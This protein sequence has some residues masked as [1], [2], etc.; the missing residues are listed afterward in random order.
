[1]IYPLLFFQ[2]ELD[3]R[4]TT[5][6]GMADISSLRRRTNQLFNEIRPYPPTSLSVDFPNLA[7]LDPLHENTSLNRREACF[8]GFS[9]VRG[10]I[11]D[12]QFR[13]GDTRI[14][15]ISA[16]VPYLDKL[17]KPGGAPRPD[18]DRKRLKPLQATT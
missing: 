4:R 7:R 3:F 15:A 9:L 12:L 10:G 1:M 18:A 2:F 8:R 5:T 14:L 17:L 11:E 13:R 6:L 16:N